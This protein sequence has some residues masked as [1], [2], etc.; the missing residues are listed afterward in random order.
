[1]KPIFAYVGV[2]LLWVLALV[3]ATALGHIVGDYATSYFR[4]KIGPVL[5]DVGV[6]RE[7]A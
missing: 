6:G 4:E 1:M 7:V 2:M 5:P 3:V